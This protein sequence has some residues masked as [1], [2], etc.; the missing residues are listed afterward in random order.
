MPCD[1]CLKGAAKSVVVHVFA[2]ETARFDMDCA[3]EEVKGVRDA[4]DSCERAG[5][6][7]LASV[8]AD[9]VGT[10]GEANAKAG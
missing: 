9:L 2:H 7:F 6:A 8:T 5:G 3:F 4:Y 1:E 10:E